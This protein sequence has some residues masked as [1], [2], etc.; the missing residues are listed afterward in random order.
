VKPAV[1]NPTP[2]PVKFPKSNASLLNHI[3]STTA[4]P[5]PPAVILP[6]VNFS[7]VALDT[8]S[9]DAGSLFTV[10]PL[11]PACT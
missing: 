1:A 3:E 6:L 10:I 8:R 4:S 5:V 7:V 9:T 2:S 11:E